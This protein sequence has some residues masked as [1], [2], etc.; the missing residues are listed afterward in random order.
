LGIWNLI[1]AIVLIAAISL[2]YPYA[3]VWTGLI[4]SINDYAWL[5]MLVMTLGMMF[6]ILLGD[7]VV[8]G[9][10]Y[11]KHGYDMCILTFGALLSHLSLQLS[12]NTDLFPGLNTGAIWGSLPGENPVAQKQ[13]VLFLLLVLSLVGTAV[14]AR[15]VRAIDMDGTKAKSL[16]SLLNFLIGSGLLGVYVLMLVAK[17]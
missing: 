4:S 13:I 1:F 11:Y 9:F 17:S 5:V 15:I 6:K 14:T 3:L 10:R 12:S 16:L 2:G 7:L 8:G